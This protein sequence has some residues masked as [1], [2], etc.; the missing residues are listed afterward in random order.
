MHSELAALLAE[1][2]RA[3]ADTNRNG[4]TATTM[5][6]TLAALSNARPA[7]QREQEQYSMRP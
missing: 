7:L 6:S 2:R 1:Y 3:A 4:Y 5:E